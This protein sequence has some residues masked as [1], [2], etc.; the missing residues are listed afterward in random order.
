MVENE[1]QKAQVLE[2][3]RLDRIDVKCLAH[4]RS[5]INENCCHYECIMMLRCNC[6]RKEDGSRSLSRIGSR[7]G[8]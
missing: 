4:S 2:S 3:C 5:L 8:S 1:E 6:P 7:E